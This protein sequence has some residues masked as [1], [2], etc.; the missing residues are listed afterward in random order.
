MRNNHQN[1]IVS[2]VDPIYE[3]KD[4]RQKIL[5][6]AGY[7]RV[8]TDSSDQEN[9][10]ANQKQYY[11]NLIRCNPNWEFVGLYVDDGISGTSIRNRKGFNLM[12]EDCLGKERKIDMII[13]KDVPRFSR[14]MA[15]FLKTV[16]LLLTCNP[17]IGVFF[18]NNN[19]NTFDPGT[20]ALLVVLSMFAEFDSA[21]KSESVRFGN[22][23]CF[24]RGDY[25]WPTNLLGYKK[26]PK[27][28]GT[29]VEGEGRYTIEIE[30]EGKKTVQLIYDLF[31]AGHSKKEIAETLTSLR[32]RTATGK[33][34]WSPSS[35]SGI[36]KN[37]KYGGDFIMQKSFVEDFKTHKAIRNKGQ[38]KLYYVPEYHEGIV[39][40]PE[41]VRALLLLKSDQSSPFYNHEYVIS[42][43][44]KGLLSGFIPMNSSFG[45]YQAS[46]YLYALEAAEV[47]F[48]EIKTEVAYIVG[49]KRV[50]KEFLG[51]RYA[52]TATFSVSGFHFNAG[53][54][55]L[56]N[57]ITHVELLL[58]P[59]ERLL[60]V[61]KTTPQ[62]RN[63]V[64]WEALSVHA[65]QL[66]H[67]VYQLMGWRKGCKYKAAANCFSKNDEQVIFFDLARCEFQCR[68]ED[69]SL[70]NAIPC[71]WISEF[72]ENL[73]EHMMLC[74]RAL[75]AKLKHWK[76]SASATPVEGFELDITLLTKEQINCRIEE[77]RCVHEKQK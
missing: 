39:S 73:P 7:A 49:A 57:K 2:E 16:D 17:P 33:T 60:A 20:R 11:E 22:N 54:I 38:R 25:F 74:R 52:A 47:S 1:R 43:V 75:A 24:E 35:V 31:L 13:V 42:V 14:N 30:P 58:H 29:G 15:D 19:I 18:E 5:L 53:C 69:K 77:L 51:N 28:E 23:A 66:M 45:G 55:S 26:V 63:S 56:M 8:S 68:E 50:R 3:N 59:S 27:I 62:N 76:L 21:W 37:E 70:T 67:V 48:Q 41:H 65:R 64:P 36:L 12:I 71:D 34:E 72:G 32:R 40:R 4:W 61:R 6:V 46:H 9:S 10:L 44:R